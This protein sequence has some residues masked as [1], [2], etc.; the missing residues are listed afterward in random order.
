MKEMAL[1]GNILIIFP[2]YTGHGP[3]TH[4][5]MAKLLTVRTC[6]LCIINYAEED[7]VRIESSAPHPI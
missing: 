1:I 6:I 4:I 2:S 7:P 5:A 3:M